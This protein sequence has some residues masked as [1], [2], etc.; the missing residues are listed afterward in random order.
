MADAYDEN[1]QLNVHGVYP[2]DVG[3]VQYIRD[4]SA[5]ARTGT[6]IAFG[7]ADAEYADLI[8]HGQMVNIATP[9]LILHGAFL[10]YTVHNFTFEMAFNPT[11][12]ANDPFLF[13]K[14]DINVAGYSIQVM[15]NGRV[16]LNTNQAAATQASDSAVGDVVVG[17][18][19]HIIVVRNGATAYFYRN[20]VP[21]VPST[22]GV[23]IS[24]AS[25]DLDF[26]MG[27]GLPTVAGN[28]LSASVSRYRSW[29]RA[30]GAAE[31]AEKYSEWAMGR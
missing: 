1:L 12:I 26:N 17:Q 31:A 13:W 19:T 18:W 10:N 21:S 2:F 9:Q 16:Q 25:S 8:G 23:H 27:S 29:S 20:G 7:G 11:T 15:A 6:P 28:D 24:P 30:M 22:V 4:F 14:G 5:Y 3:G